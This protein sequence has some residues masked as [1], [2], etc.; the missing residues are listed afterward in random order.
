MKKA[1]YFDVE[2]TGLHPWHNDIIQIACLVEINGEVVEEYTANMQPFS[3]ENVDAKALKINNTTVEELKSYPHPK[4]IHAELCKLF[5]KYINKFDKQDKFAPIG[6]NVKFDCDFLSAF[7]RKNE[8]RY[9][10]SWVNWRTVDPLALLYTMDYQRKIALPNYKL[11]TVCQH[12]GIPIK[13]HDAL[14]DIR[15]TRELFQ[16]LNEMEL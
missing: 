9:Y 10:G 15:A 7:F 14:S 2:T 5:E 11:A 4:L 13:A 3:F 12:F 6:Y 16:T 1:L 8:D